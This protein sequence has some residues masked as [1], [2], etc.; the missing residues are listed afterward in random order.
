MAMARNFRKGGIFS[1]TPG[2][3]QV[4]IRRQAMTIS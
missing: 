4:A 3:F 2:H 1:A